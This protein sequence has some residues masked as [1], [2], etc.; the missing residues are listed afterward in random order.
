MFGIKIVTKKEL[1]KIE[2]IAK[3]KAMA[4]LIELLRKKDK[5]I[6]EPMTLVGD[7]QIVKDCV[8]FSNDKNSCLNIE[9]AI[10]EPK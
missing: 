8:F 10:V 7:H 4:E 1:E 5:I 3:N 2:S 9:S 6:L